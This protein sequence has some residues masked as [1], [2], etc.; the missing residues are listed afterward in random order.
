MYAYEVRYTLYH[1]NIMNLV[2]S[3]NSEYRDS[4]YYPDSYEVLNLE[5]VAL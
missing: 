3:D 1:I 5:S 4:E 2:L